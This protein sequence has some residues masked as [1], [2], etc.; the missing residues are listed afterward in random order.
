MKG[1]NGSEIVP[2]FAEIDFET[3]KDKND[4]TVHRFDFIF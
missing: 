3:G 4:P 1:P 2:K